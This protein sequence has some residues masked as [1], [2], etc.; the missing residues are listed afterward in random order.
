VLDARR[1]HLGITGS[2]EWTEFS[3]DPPEGRTLNLSFQGR[4]NAQEATLLLLQRDVK[5]DWTVLLNGRSIGRLMPWEAPLIHALAIPPAVL[6]DGENTLVVAGPSQPDDIV[7]DHVALD[8]RPVRDALGR[9]TLDVSVTE[10]G[11]PVPCRITLAGTDGVLRPL[12]IE[13]K[14][15]LA[16]RPGVVYTPNGQAR[17]GLPPGPVA[18]FASR[19][20]EYGVSSKR[21]DLVD[22]QRHSLELAIRREVSTPGL[23]ACDTHVHTL[24]HSGHGDATIE[25]RAITLA[26]EGIELAVATD[27]DVFTDLNPVALEL[28]VRSCFTP[29]V[30]DEVTTRAGHFNAFPFPTQ[31][32]VP[33]SRI[34]DWPRLLEAIRTRAAR[35]ASVIILNH[36]R[37][38]HAGFRPFDPAQFNPA[39]GAHR[40]G[41]IGVDALEVVSSGA[42]QSD[43]MRLVHDWMALINHGDRVTAVGAS[44]SHDVARFIVGQGRTY[45][46]CPDNDVGS[47]D[48]FSACHA[49]RDGRALVSLGLLANL[50]VD[51]RFQVGDLATGCDSSL[52]VKVSVLYPSWSGVDRVTLFANG[53]SLREQPVATAPGAAGQTEVRWEIPCPG[54]DIYLVAVASG[55]GI[56]APFW[57]IPRPY[58]PTSRKWTPRV[59]ALTNPIYIDG[60][61]DGKWTSPRHYASRQVERAGT[62]TGRLLRALDSF[63]EAVAAQ[64]AGLCDAAGENI[65]APDFTRALAT[66]SQPVQ[67]GFAAFAA[68]LP[69]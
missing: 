68:T 14:S 9:A 8:E 38:L 30:G 35:E 34:T 49:L 32:L 67:R 13:P 59:L 12:V 27:H 56:T 18:V 44:D 64:A 6:H 43:P 47:I 11:S 19:G 52:R 66:A 40:R 69:P 16:A 54:H 60:D 24:T 25:E 55:P 4:T 28:G 36:P 48:V 57:A 15:P 29:V 2:P 62:A 46:A 33:D 22:G 53:V 5:L 42:L 37:D 63:D 61:R 17:I 26:A 51:G 45:V 58:Q 3:G 65:R 21:L 41:T 50:T 7:I 20:F 39:T 1:H 10:S 31:S 23:V